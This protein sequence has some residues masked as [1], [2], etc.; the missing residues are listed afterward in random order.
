MYIQNSSNSTGCSQ[1][2]KPMN[3]VRILEKNGF[4]HYGTSWKRGM[5]SDFPG[6]YQ[7][8]M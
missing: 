8:Y 7:R 2:E 1:Y 3:N 4:R 5:H 6:L